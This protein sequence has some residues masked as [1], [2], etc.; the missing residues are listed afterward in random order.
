MKRSLKEMCQHNRINNYKMINE[1]E[2][3]IFKLEELGL[4]IDYKAD[5][6]IQ[7]KVNATYLFN[8]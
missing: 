2:E 5:L 8:K 6:N 1:N 4:F 3:L 7:N